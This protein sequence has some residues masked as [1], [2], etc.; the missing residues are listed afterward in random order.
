MTAREIITTKCRT[1]WRIRTIAFVALGL[2][3]VFILF[4][5]NYNNV[6]IFSFLGIAFVAF[7]M[8][9][10]AHDVFTKRATCPSCKKR[11]AHLMGFA[12]FV[13]VVP[14]SFRFCP[15]CGLPL[16]HEF[17]DLQKVEANQSS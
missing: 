1:P 8:M 9:N 13:V 3:T 16:D 12:P 5:S 6:L 11:I 7:I 2:N 17:S 10:I 14:N 15:F 4:C